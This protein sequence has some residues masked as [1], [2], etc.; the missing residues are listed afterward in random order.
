MKTDR[1][2]FYMAEHEPADEP[3]GAQCKFDSEKSWGNCTIEHHYMVQK[4]KH[5]WPD[6]QTRLVYARPQR[7]EPL[8]D[9][10]LKITMQ[11]G[12]IE[13]SRLVSLDVIK[14]SNVPEIERHSKQVWL[15]L[16]N[17]IGSKP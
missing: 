13:A 7:S 11:I 6:Y 14:T 4:E 2:H 3:V 10:M 8:T 1:E 9:G 12:D 15:D 16:Q 5:E 17:G